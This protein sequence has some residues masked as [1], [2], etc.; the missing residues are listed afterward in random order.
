LWIF[1]SVP[2]GA[3]TGLVVAGLHG[4][5]FILWLPLSERS[6]WWIAL[7]PTAGLCLAA[8]LL[9]MTPGRSTATTEAYIETFHDPARRMPLREVPLRLA[10]SI[11]T[12]AL[13]GSM[14]LEGPSVYAGAA[15]GDAK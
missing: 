5:I 14:G 1:L 3:A 13:G 8:V 11:S 9:S 4:A 6:S 15:I 2:V 12:I 10:A 7:L